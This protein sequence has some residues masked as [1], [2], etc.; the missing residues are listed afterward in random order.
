MKEFDIVDAITIAMIF[1]PVAAVSVLARLYVKEKDE[2][3]QYMSHL[4]KELSM[5]EKFVM[6]NSSNTSL[7]LKILACYLFM[8]AVAFKAYEL[9]QLYVWIV[10]VVAIIVV[11]G[12]Y[13]RTTGIDE[14]DAALVVVRLLGKISEANRIGNHQK[15]ENLSKLCDY[16]ISKFELIKTGEVFEIKRHITY[17]D[18][19]TGSERTVY[20]GKSLLTRLYFA[21]KILVPVV[22]SVVVAVLLKAAI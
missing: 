1:L 10:P 4:S 2:L 15:V 3:E 6:E 18:T 22:L 20:I 19:L 17:A 12:F 14:N 9:N 7:F 5:D 13:G 16:T 21:L 11:F 8:G